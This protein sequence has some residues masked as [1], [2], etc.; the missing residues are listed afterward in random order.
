MTRH[1]RVRTAIAA[2]ALTWPHLATAQTPDLDESKDPPL[3]PRVPGSWIIAYDLKQLDA[4]E[5]PLGPTEG[6]RF[7]RSERVRGKVT[8]VWAS[9]S[10]SA[11][12]AASFARRYT[13]FMRRSRSSGERVISASFIAPRH[14][15][16]IPIGPPTR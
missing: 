4:Y 3:L 1:S 16:A 14:L 13:S 8:T 11:G 10:L 15:D 9:T 5:L 6:N 2:L 12:A 7:S